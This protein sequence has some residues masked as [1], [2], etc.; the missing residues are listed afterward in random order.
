M[1]IASDFF[2]DTV[3][4]RVYHS[5]AGTTVYTVQA[6]YSYLQDLMD[7]IA[8][9]DFTPPMSAQTPTA[10]TMVNG[11]YMDEASIQYLKGGS[12][13]SIGYNAVVYQLTFNSSGYT[14]AVATDIGSLLHNAGSTHTG[15]LLNYNNT[16]RVWYIRAVTS[17]F[18]AT[19]VCTLTIQAPGTTGT[20]AGTIATAGVV[21]GESVYPNLYTLGTID[22]TGATQQIYI[23]Q[24]KVNLFTSLPGWWP[25]PATPTNRQIDVLIKTQNMGTVI[26]SG[27]L[28]IML[29]HDP[30]TVNTADTYDHFPITVTGGRNAVPLAT[31]LD[32]N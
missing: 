7:D 29:R 23:I 5:G 17:V 22:Q 18:A 10:F 3:T 13:V 21:T 24:N 27:N 30:N 15:V 1:P 28:T 9:M 11:W 4:Q 20:G 8:N 14:N 16:T 25:D 26:D 2:I 6:L 12:I 31:A 19:D 32:L